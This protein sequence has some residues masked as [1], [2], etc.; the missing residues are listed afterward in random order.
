M[1]DLLP[2]TSP[3]PTIDQMFIKHMVRV[4][5]L[6]ICDFRRTIAPEFVSIIHTTTLDIKKR[7]DALNTMR[8]CEPDENN[9]ANGCPP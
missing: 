9:S 7:C 1:I 6:S 5:A 4:V 2:M 3:K 8:S